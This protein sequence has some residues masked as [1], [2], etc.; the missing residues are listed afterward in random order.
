MR[1]RRMA[2]VLVLAVAGCGSGDPAP[3]P[4]GDPS[5]K[6][7][8]PASRAAL[9][10]PR[11]EVAGAAWSGGVVVV[12]GYRA[13]GSS[14]P[15]VDLWRPADDRWTRLPELP[16]GRNHPAAAVLND[17]LFVSGGRG[18]G[19]PRGSAQVWSIGS[20]ETSWRA[21]P[22]LRQARN[23]H[24]MAAVE[25]KLVVAGGVGPTGLLTSVEVLMGG[26]WRPVPPLKAGREHLGGVASAGRMWVIAGRLGGLATNLGTVESWRPGEPEWR[27]EPDLKTPRGGVAAGERAGEVCVAGGEQPSGTIGTVECLQGG[28]WEVIATLAVPR[29]G[30][31]VVGAP[32]GLHVIAGGPQPGLTV[33]GEH[34]VV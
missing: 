29:H 2:L 25:G 17:R 21:E 28:R 3:Q 13:D 20:G 4:K 14:S 15:R 24:A 7:A 32:D 26:S 6:S 8:G 33:S 34:E 1:I 12:G 19:A 23:A 10:E 18:D 31:A 27:R 30:L 9:P 16:A 11:S 5:T 22:A